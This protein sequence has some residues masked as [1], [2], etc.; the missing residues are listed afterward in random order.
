MVPVVV[1]VMFTCVYKAHCRVRWLC[2]TV[3]WH[4]TGLLWCKFE[5]SSDYFSLCSY[6]NRKKL[7]VNQSTLLGSFEILVCHWST[8]PSW[9]WM[10]PIFI[11]TLA[12]I[13]QIERIVH[14]LPWIMIFGSKVR[15]FANNFH[16]W[17]SYVR[18]SLANCITSHPKIFIHGN[19][20]II[21]FLTCYLMFLNTHFPKAIIDHWFRH[22]C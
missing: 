21:L 11:S 7:T 1:A 18:K 6:Y 3:R 9:C 15:W 4:I 5:N 10:K 8:I 12:T 19:K 22:C 20:C 17:R 16:E 13:V 2:C 14:E